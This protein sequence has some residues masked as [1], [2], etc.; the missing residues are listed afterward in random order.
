MNDRHDP[1]VCVGDDDLGPAAA[2]RGEGLR[3][4]QR[5]APAPDRPRVPRLKGRTPE[6]GPSLSNRNGAA[7]TSRTQSPNQTI[8][9]PC[10]TRPGPAGPSKT[11][12][13][14]PHYSYTGA[15]SSHSL[16]VPPK[17]SLNS[18]FVYALL[19]AAMRLSAVWSSR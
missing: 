8:P 6:S 15:M 13:G 11:P 12:L 10:R 17:T 9:G 18:C 5:P 1:M 7:P 2:P 4:Q 16:L 14:V 19:S 3:P